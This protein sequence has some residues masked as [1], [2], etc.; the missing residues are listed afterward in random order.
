MLRNSVPTDSASMG[1]LLLFLALAVPFW[2]KESNA[3]HKS[4]S[5]GPLL[6]R[7][8]T[9]THELCKQ[10]FPY[11]YLRSSSSLFMK[12]FFFIS[13]NRIQSAVYGKYLRLYALG[14]SRQGNISP[15]HVGAPHKHFPPGTRQSE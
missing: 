5:P 13:S 8:W 9:D 11:F 12:P 15:K 7:H 14:S 2:S 6:F 4:L 3:Y 1:F 10:F